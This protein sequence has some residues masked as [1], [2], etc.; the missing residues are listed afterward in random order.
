MWKIL[1]RSKGKSKPKKSSGFILIIGLM[2]SSVLDPAN[3]ARVE[4]I[5]QMKRRRVDSGRE[6]A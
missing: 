2:F 3:K 6:N 5:S 4:G 1:A